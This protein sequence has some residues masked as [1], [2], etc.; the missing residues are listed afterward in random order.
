MIAKGVL[1]RAKDHAL[2]LQL[3][4]ELDVHDGAR[5]LHDA[6]RARAVGQRSRDDVGHSLWSRRG[7]GR[8]RVQV[9]ALE[10]RRP[11]TRAAPHGQ[12]EPL[13]GSLCRLAQLLKRATVACAGAGQCVIEGRLAVA[14]GLHLRRRSAAGRTAA[15]GARTAARGRAIAVGSLVVA[16]L[17]SDTAV[18]GG[19]GVE[20]AADL[21][22]G[23]RHSPRARGARPA[24]RRPR[25]RSARPS[26]CARTRASRSA[27]CAGSG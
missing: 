11:E 22:G 15:S 25:A 10:A 18:T 13:E 6:P 17:A 12:L 23:S 1:Q 4:V 3:R 16:G 7:V 5:A 8:Q 14:S 26:R 21:A 2:G 9:D 19:H 24:R 27:G 20:V